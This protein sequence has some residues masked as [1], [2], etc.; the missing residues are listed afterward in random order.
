MTLKEDDMDIERLNKTLADIEAALLQMKRFHPGL[1]FAFNENLRLRIHKRGD[2][3]LIDI[4]I[5]VPVC[6]KHRR[7]PALTAVADRQCIIPFVGHSQGHH[8]G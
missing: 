6:H 5:S 2:G 4:G 1:A 7:R 3:F 8:S